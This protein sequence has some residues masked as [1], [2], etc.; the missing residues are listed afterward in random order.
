MISKNTLRS[1]VSR[2]LASAVRRTGKRSKSRNSGVEQLETRAL[3]AVFTVTSTADANA[4]SLRQAIIDAN[5]AAGPDQIVFAPSTNGTE[6]DLTT[7]QMTITETVTITGNGAGNT[8][9]DAQQNSRIFDITSTAGNVTINNLTLKNGRTTGNNPDS[10]TTTHSGGAIRSASSGTLTIS[11]SALIENSTTGTRADG[12]AIRSQSGPIVILDSTLEGNSTVG[13]QSTG[14]AIFSRAGA[15]SIGRSTLSGNSTGGNSAAGGAI[16]TYDLSAALTISQSTL[17][18]N[19]TAGTLSEGGAFLTVFGPVLVSQSTLTLNNAASSAGGAIFSYSS[20]LTINNSIVAGNTDN[21]TAPDVRKSPS[22]ALSVSASLIGRNNGTDLT[23]TGTSN[24]VP[25][26]NFIGGNSV[27]TAIDPLLGPLRLNG[28]LTKNHALL[29]GSLA[30]DW[31]AAILALDPL[32]GNAALTHDQRGVPFVRDSNGFVDMGAHERHVFNAPIVVSTATDELDGDLTSGDLSLREAITLANGSPG[33]NTITFA[34]ST[35][36]SPFR[37]SLGQLEIQDT[38]NITGNGIENTVIDGQQLSRILE[39]TGTA[40]DVTLSGLTLQNGRTTGNHVLFGPPTHHGGA[41]RSLTT[42]TLTISDSLVSQN[43]TTG[44]GAAGGAIFHDQGALSVVRSTLSGNTTANAAGGAILSYTGTTTVRES[45]LFGNSTSGSY[46]PGGAIF[47]I[48]GSINVLQSTI[49]GNSTTGSNAHGAGLYSSYGGILVVQSTITQNTA[50]AGEGGGIFRDAGSGDINIRNSIIAGNTDNNTASDIRKPGTA[51]LLVSGSLIGRSNGTNLTP[52]TGSTKDGNGNFVGGLTDATKINPQLGSLRINGGA[53]RTHALLPGS[54]AIDN[55]SNSEAIDPINGANIPFTTDQRGVLVPRITN[56]TVDMGAYE[57]LT[58]ASPIIVSAVL[59]EVDTNLGTGNLSLREAIIL[60]NASPGADTITFASSLDGNELDLTLGHMTITDPVTITGRGLSNTII[61]AQQMSRVFDITTTAGNVQLNGMTLKQGRTTSNNVSPFGGPV[62]NGGAIRSLTTGTLTISDSLLTGNSTVGDIAFGGAVFH[63]GGSLVVVRSTLS[64]NT[65]AGAGAIGGAIGT[66]GGTTIIR[67]STLSGNSTT[68]GNAGGGAIGLTGGSLTIVQSTVSGNTTAQADSHGAGIYSGLEVTITQSTITL[69]N[70]Q[71]ATGG[72][73]YTVSGTSSIRNSIIAENYSSSSYDISQQVG[74]TLNISGSLIGRSD[75]TTLTPTTGLTPDANG[76]LIGGPTDSGR[77][78][79]LLGP[80]ENQGGST[81]VHVPNVVSPV[82]NAGR[83]VNAVDPSNSN[84]LISGD[85]RGFPN[86]R[87]ADGIVDMGAFELQ[88]GAI[89]V[90]SNGDDLDNITSPGNLS[91]REAVTVANTRPFLTNIITFSS[92]TNSAELDL[93]NGQIA[94]N[95]PMTITGN[96]SGNTVINAHQLSRIF[97]VTESANSFT[98]NN[99][100]LKNG[101]TTASNSSGGAI[102]TESA[103]TGPVTINNSVLTGN[104]TAGIYSG[105]GAVYGLGAVLT[106]SRSTLNGNSTS[107][108]SSVGGA[109]V[110]RS[111]TIRESTFSGNSTSGNFSTGGAVFASFQTLVISQST[112]SGNSVTGLS[113]GGAIAL[114]QSGILVLSQSTLTQNSAP[115]GEGGAIVT[116]SAAVTIRNSIIAGNA[117]NASPSSTDIK[118]NSSTA[119][120]ITNSLIGRSD[121]TTLTPTVGTTPNANGNF[122]GGITDATKISPLLAPLG[123]NGGPTL[124]HPLQTGSLA[125]NRGSNASAVDVTNGNVALTTDQRGAGF[126]RITA[127]TVDMGAFES[128]VL[129]GTSGT[130][131]FV[132]TYSST[133]TTGTVNVTVSTNGGPATSLGTFSMTLPLALD[134]LGG[135]DS[136]RIVGTTGD[137]TIT[138]NSST[139]LIV[140]GSS[141]TVSN[142]ETRTLAGAAGSDVYRFDADTALGLWTLA[143]SGVGIDT[144]DFSPTTTVGLSMNMA[145]GGV[146]AVHGTNLSL[147]LG[148]GVTIEN[149][150]GGSGADNLIGNGLNN[151]LRGGPGNDMLNGALGND[152]LFGG[153]NN[154]TYLFGAASVAEADEVSENVNEGI[155]TLNFAFLTTNV[156]LNMA[157]NSVQAVHANRTLKLNSPITFENATGGSGADYLIGNT[158]NNTLIGG[159]GTDTL[160]GALGSDFLLGGANNDTYLFGP[161]S[162]AEADQ[163]T[164]NFNEGTDTLNFATLTT[165]IVVNLGANSIQAVHLNRTLKLNSPI[166]FENFIGGS[167]A[168]YLIGNS[169]NNTLT[170]G[171]GDDTLNGAGGSDL[172]IGGANN[173]SYLFGAASAAEA[174]QVIENANEGIDLLNFAFLTTDV[175][176]NLGSLTVQPVHLNRTLKLNSVSTFENAMGGTGS[177]T[178]LG[179]ALANRLTGGNGNNILVGLE[180][181]DILVAGTGRDILIGGPGLDVLNAGAGDDILIAGRT[182]SDTSLTSLNTLR[183]A[184]ISADAYTTRVT[185]L[186]AGVGSPLVSLKAKINVLNDAGE[187]DVIVGGTNSDWFFR[188]LDDVITDLVAGELIDVL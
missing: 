108:N 158:L 35:M 170:G 104:S 167:G 25:G 45:T 180:G 105:G 115:L 110:G 62:N 178:L 150:T 74:A 50:V 80:L 144:V 12:G 175:V 168:D 142:I 3:L 52:T 138:V 82:I 143:E 163:V 44:T 154:D 60:A 16:F 43:S 83:N 131:A 173:D 24:P 121:G 14:G 46:A 36:G 87:I 8:I 91:L 18:A 174:D 47:S 156:V 21:G 89:V 139:G 92:S 161:A 11:G 53:T 183:A 73:L 65:T 58:V 160:N 26:N 2:A 95:V 78:N 97:F 137:D 55:G 49:S 63:D 153:A 59:D 17:S 39:I 1:L 132:L 185:N 54:L 31:A 20:Q 70:A 166:T 122:I 136:V 75:G 19:S 5:A 188:A 93:N 119:P 177:D 103:F 164:E 102:R 123:N 184:W 128:T 159:A 23:A 117:S 129:N 125:L 169:L 141:L 13:L 118:I 30:I 181:A 147:S 116:S 68:G 162:V 155:D 88:I 6:F 79:P 140:N 33:V 135:T 38:L 114:Q 61:D 22:D 151:T 57:L 37:L 111:I 32:N 90:S 149:A 15:V 7:G 124:T 40:G 84:A 48:G 145:F 133:T 112:F 94:I 69:N 146:Q 176:L 179:N 96:G 10:S 56:T 157:A 77:I 113:S 171:A 120:V 126:A 41:I 28:G 29:T 134:G 98:L 72:G 66:Y 64:G 42:G 152:F 109:V 71:L 99:V 76:N 187:D 148:S 107:G 165:S 186:R 101:R 34:A 85:Q 182:T 81:E 100:T 27:G 172:L 127:G 4:G 130:D 67:N 86:L 51:S 9:V 106:I